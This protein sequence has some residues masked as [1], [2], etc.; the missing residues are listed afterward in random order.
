MSRVPVDQLKISPAGIR[1][2]RRWEGFV[3]FPY[4]DKVYPYKEYKGGPLRGTLTI[5]V[6]HTNLSGLPPKVQVGARMTEAQ[7][8]ETLGRMLDK[9]YQPAVRRLVKVPLYQREYDALVSLC[10]NM[11]EPN[12]ANSSL[13]A[14]LNRGDYRGAADAFRLYRMSGGV[15]MRGLINRREDERRYFLGNAATSR[16]TATGTAGTVVAVGAGK[17][18]QDA[19]DSP[20]I[21]IVVGAVVV[22]LV[23]AV[24]ILRRRK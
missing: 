18:V 4:D 9:V 10:Y 19:T 5:G 15:V 23:V 22:A 14:T 12:L 8:M 1:L 13:I 11:G 3:P 24:I 2:I 21:A 20:S 6:G 7:A 16:E 17:A